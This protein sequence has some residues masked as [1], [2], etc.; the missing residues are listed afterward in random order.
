MSVNN[1]ALRQVVRRHLDGDN[2]TRQDFDAVEAHLAGKVRVDLVPV[3][4][5]NAE[6]RRGKKFL[7]FA[8]HLN[9]TLAFVSFSLI[10]CLES[11]AHT[12]KET[13]SSRGMI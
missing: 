12:L 13:S 5:Q 2:V 11:W 7:H 6:C 1:P 9:K 10:G 4:Q 8:A 3:F